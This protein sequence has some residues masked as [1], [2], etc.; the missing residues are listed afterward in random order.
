MCRATKLIC[1]TAKRMLDVSVPRKRVYVIAANKTNISEP[2]QASADCGLLE[3]STIDVIALKPMAISMIR[4][5]SNCCGSIL[6][7]EKSS[8]L[9]AM[10]Q[11]RLVFKRR[12]VTPF[13]G[14]QSHTLS[15]GAIEA[16]HSGYCLLTSS[17]TLK[18][19]ALNLLNPVCMA[20]IQ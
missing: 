2:V 4:S 1:N 6:D 7:V 19:Q 13:V 9:I 17:H 16:K 5:P 3:P 8:D 15:W 11:M 10:M 14:I 20:W 18:V 12:W